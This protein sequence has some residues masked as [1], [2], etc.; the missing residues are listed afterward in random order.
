MRARLRLRFS[1]ISEQGIFPHGVELVRGDVPDG[2]RA[3][4]LAACTSLL[5]AEAPHNVS[6][7]LLHLVLGPSS[8]KNRKLVSRCGSLRSTVPPSAG[9]MTDEL[10]DVST[11]AANVKGEAR[12]ECMRARVARVEGGGSC[13]MS[14]PSFVSV[15]TARELERV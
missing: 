3:A 15:R 5:A 12:G 11:C 14:S 8:S 1:Q 10:Q 7:S 9:L 6:L 2:E 13:K 4:L